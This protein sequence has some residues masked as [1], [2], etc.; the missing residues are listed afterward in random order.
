MF[1]IVPRSD[2][3]S[4]IVGDFQECLDRIQKDPIYCTLNMIRVFRYVKE[5]V[6]SSKEE[7]G[8]WGLAHLPKELSSTVNK[9]IDCYSSEKDDCQFENDELLRFRDYV[10]NNVQT[11]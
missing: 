5:G 10:T 2:Y 1:P 9:I 6:I 7:A 8:R 4:S 3:L 11:F